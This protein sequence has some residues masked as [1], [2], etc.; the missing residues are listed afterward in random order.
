MV[1]KA[2]KEVNEVYEKYKKKT[3]MTYTELKIWSLN[4]TSKLASIDRSPLRRNL[5]LLSKPRYKWNLKD[6][7]DANK[8][9]SYISRARKIKRKKGIPK[10]QLTPNE[11]AL[12]N[13]G[14][15]SFK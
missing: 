3:N 10:N 9:I 5:R 7:D 15:D 12:K 2:D 11:I 1:N 13:W 8:T 14:Y 6:V 4:P